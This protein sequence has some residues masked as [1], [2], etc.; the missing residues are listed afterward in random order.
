MEQACKFLGKPIKDNEN[1]LL[2]RINPSVLDDIPHLEEDLIDDFKA[3][4]GEYDV[5]ARDGLVGKKFIYLQSVLAHLLRRRGHDYRMEN[6]TMVKNKNTIEAHN[7]ICRLGFERLGWDI[8]C[9]HKITL[10]TMGLTKPIGSAGVATRLHNN[11]F[12]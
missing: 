3:F 11:H 6:L 9:Y 10:Y 2:A 5:L 12:S 8:Q 1:A 4:S 7:D